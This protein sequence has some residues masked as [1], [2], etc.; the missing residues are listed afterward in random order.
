MGGSKKEKKRIFPSIKWFVWRAECWDPI[1]TLLQQMLLQFQHNSICAPEKTYHARS[2][3]QAHSSKRPLTPKSVP[4]NF[5]STSH[6]RKKLGHVV[7]T[8]CNHKQS[9]YVD[10]AKPPWNPIS[11]SHILW[12]VSAQSGMGG[13]SLSSRGHLRAPSVASFW[14]PGLPAR[15]A[16][17]S[18][19]PGSENRRWQL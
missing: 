2:L 6:R 17:L 19:E 14:E 8:C 11:S 1:S 9:I 10:T 5:P 12:K 15:A 16:A 18:P 3:L 13:S 7:V 4:Q